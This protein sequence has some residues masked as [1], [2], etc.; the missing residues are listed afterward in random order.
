M[1]INYA[2]IFQ[3]AGC[4]IICLYGE[5]YGAGIQSGGNYRKDQ[6]FILFDVKIDH[7]WLKRSGVE[8]IANKLDTEI[9]PIIGTGNLFDLV[10]KAKKGFLS[11]ISKIH[12]AEGIVARPAVELFS[13][14][15]DRIITK[16]KYK[17]FEREK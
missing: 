14:N 10:D 13:R 9:V 16:I 12:Y 7:L 2:N 15:G 8:D 4:N 17:D 6:S 3:P 5:G 1:K 11:Q